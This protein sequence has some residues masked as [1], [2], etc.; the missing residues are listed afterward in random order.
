MFN[1]GDTHY[2]RI[3]IEGC[4]GTGKSTLV[5]K[6]E[7]EFTPSMTVHWTSPPKLELKEYHN[8]IQRLLNLYLRIGTEVRNH[9]IYDRALLSEMIYAPIFKGYDMSS[10][11]YYYSKAF[12]NKGWKVVV[13]TANFETVKKRVQDRGDWLITDNGKLE[14]IYDS[15]EYHVKKSSIPI[16]KFQSDLKSDDLEKTQ[17]N[18]LL[19]FL[20]G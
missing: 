17:W 1:I 8:Y 4:D 3:V 13:C 12:H 11:N 10:F 15:Y 16:F 20:K 14:E 7:D 6:L 18:Q 5:K 19:H 2:H 9:I